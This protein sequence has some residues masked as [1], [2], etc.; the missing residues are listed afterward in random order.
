MLL[1]FNKIIKVEFGIY[2]IPEELNENKIWGTINRN[3]IIR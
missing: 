3:T 1:I 2:K